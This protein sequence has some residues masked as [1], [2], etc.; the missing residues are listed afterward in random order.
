MGTLV[1][2]FSFDGNTKFIAEKIA[3]TINADIIELKSSK[4]YPTE[5]F[6]KYFWGGKSVI[7]GEKP[8]LINDSI[9]FNRYE[10]VFIGTP[11]WAGSY[12]PPIKSFIRQYKLQGKRIA[13]FACHGGN[14]AEKCF[15]KLKAALP[16]NKFIGE[17][18]FLEPKKNS[19]ESSN[20]A[21]KWADGLRTI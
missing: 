14:G 4:K 13:L 5:G 17:M 9:D 18:A 12:T 6:S 10:T 8:K 7:F 20:K 11:V 2:Y 19:E 15:A 1:V 16:G 3:E 21:V